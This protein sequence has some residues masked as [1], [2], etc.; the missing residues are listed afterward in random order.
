MADAR[1]S[2]SLGQSAERGMLVSLRDGRR[3]RVGAMTPT[4][5]AM[6]TELARLVAAEGV[7][8]PW[9]PDE[10]VRAALRGR[11]KAAWARRADERGI[12][13]VARTTER[14]SRVVGRVRLVRGSLRRTRHV[15]RVDILIH[16][17]WR[18]VGLGRAMLDTAIGWAKS[19]SE[20]CILTLRVLHTNARAIALYERCGFRREGALRHAVRMGDGSF[21][22]DVLMAREVG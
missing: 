1:A 16:P 3:V 12:T 14:P 5:G 9:E 21:V 22:D 20:V 6:V 11:G 13:F 8:S 18:G 10:V 19:D 15:A 2:R 17:N 4:E 7:Y